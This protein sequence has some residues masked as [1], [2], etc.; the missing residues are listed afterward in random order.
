MRIA[1][2]EQALTLSDLLNPFM[3]PVLVGNETV[4]AHPAHLISI[5][6]AA[7]RPL[8]IGLEIVMRDIRSGRYGIFFILL[9]GL[10]MKRG[11]GARRLSLR[12]E[13]SQVRSASSKK[14]LNNLWQTVMTYMVLCVFSIVLKLHVFLWMLCDRPTKR[15]AEVRRGR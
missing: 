6:P 4:P 15:S 11:T 8:L 3:N 7:A 1:N 12:K 10:Q 14:S 2:P 13:T 5:Y 9:F